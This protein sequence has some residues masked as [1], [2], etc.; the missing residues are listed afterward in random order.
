MASAANFIVRDINLGERG[1]AMSRGVAGSIVSIGFPH[2]LRGIRIENLRN[3]HLF[4]RPV[5]LAQRLA[6]FAHG[7]I[8][9]HTIDN[10][11]HGVGIADAAIGANHRLLGSGLF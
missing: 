11:R 10:E 2:P 1:E 6:N 3:A 9:S 7:G 4:I 5:N 8:R